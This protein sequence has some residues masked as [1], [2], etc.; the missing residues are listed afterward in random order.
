MTKKNAVKIQNL[1]KS[2]KLADNSSK[3]ALDNIS[4][5]IPEGKIFGLLG[6]NGAGKSTII[7]ILAGLTLKT[8]GYVEIL[9]LNQTEKPTECKYSIGV[10]PQELNIDPF[11][12]P[13][14][15]IDTQAGLYGIRKKDRRTNEILAA[16]GLED[17]ANSYSRDLSGGMR[18]RLLIG[19][20]LVH[21]PPIL[22]LDEPTAGVDIEL[23]ETLWKHIIGLKE[24][25]T[26][27]ILT[28]HYLEEAE[29]MCEE[30]AILRQ[31]RLIESSSKDSILEKLGTH[32]IH[33]KFRNK[34]K[35]NSIQIIKAAFPKE[36][37]L[38]F[39][40]DECLVLKFKPKDLSTQKLLSLLYEIKS[41]IYSFHTLEPSLNDVFKEITRKKSSTSSVS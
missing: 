40:E 9:G 20:A 8:S 21:N 36:I 29:K 11:L 16:I 7:N 34:L 37:T 1:N 12:T 38:D 39:E 23:R 35:R 31:G 24:Q 6:P 5:I 32:S 30:I 19:K 25:G 15:S 10:V 28:T 18:R 2:Y 33:I 27:I 17:K 4:L 41:E 26:T 3:K 13:K 14:E 22:I